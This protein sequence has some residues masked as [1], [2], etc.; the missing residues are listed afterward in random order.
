M[1]RRPALRAPANDGEVLAVPPLEDAG[2]VVA[3]NQARLASGP[4]L[5]GRTFAEVR[6]LARRE[7]VH[8]PP[9]PSPSSAGERR[10]LARRASEAAHHAKPRAA[11]GRGGPLFLA[12]HQPELFHPGVWVKNF[13]LAG[14]AARHHGTA[15][16]FLV[17]ND[18]LKSP[19]LTFPAP[20]ERPRLLRLAF[21]RAEAEVPWEER[22]VLDRAQFTAFGDRVAEQL[23][24]WG[25]EPLISEVWPEVIRHIDGPIGTA[26]A[27]G[28]RFVERQWGCDNLETPLSAISG[29]VGFAHFAGAIV[30]D[31]ARFH[32]LYNRT[33]RAY[34]VRRRIRSRH[35]PVPDLAT[36]GDWLEAP[37]WGWRAGQGRGRLF[38]RH[39]AGKLHLRAGK[40]EWPV[41]PAPEAS[42][43]F[44]AAWRD[45]ARQGY[46]VRPRALT[47]TLF[48]R[49]LL[50]DVFVHGIGGAIYDEL[51]DELI[52]AYFHLEPP[53]FIV[54]SATVRLPLPAFPDTLDDRR[55]LAR[56]I[57]DIQY[58]P[59]RHLFGDQAADLA[60]TLEERREW[61]EREPD[62]RVGRRERF[63]QL[64]ALADALRVPLATQ[65]A[66]LRHT[67]AALDDRLASNAILRRRDYSFVSYP[68]SVL[69]PLCSRFM[70]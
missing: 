51:T 56:Q 69:R 27:A 13:A 66:E 61:L 6:E 19:T 68:A 57:R 52:R 58:N 36:D 8:S 59:Q 15:V 5:L 41:L 33:V 50:A 9:N 54:L 63:R 45:L 55:R 37:F 1:S 43:P 64:R 34:R 32:A 53:E 48:A 67:L 44:L 40:D 62:T 25:Y 28:R 21:D 12:G 11:E 2:A 42:E 17:D 38:V 70:R 4:V 3:R 39:A 46:K 16:N 22:F 20:G 23:R 18:T 49:L 7:L 29:G 31:I 60:A 47:T 35:H 26:F 30:G 65:V 10:E 24:G 14:L